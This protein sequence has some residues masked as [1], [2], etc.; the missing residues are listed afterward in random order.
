VLTVEGEA[1]P[2]PATGRFADEATMRTWFKSPE[3]AVFRARLMSKAAA[4]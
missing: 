4:Q 1:C 3:R 2:L